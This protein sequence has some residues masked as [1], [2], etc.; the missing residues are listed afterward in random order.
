MSTTA[1]MSRRQPST[2]A[3]SVPIQAVTK[4]SLTD[5]LSPEERD[6]KK[7]SQAQAAETG[8]R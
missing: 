1:D 4:R 5:T 2:N 6:R 7:K 3:V 8:E